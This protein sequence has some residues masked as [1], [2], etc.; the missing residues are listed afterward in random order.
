MP[1]QATNTR[2]WQ[3]A[4][5]CHNKAAFI[6]SMAN[7]LRRG[8]IKQHQYGDVM[9]PFVALKRLDQVLAPH[10]DAVHAG[11]TK[12]TVERPLKGQG[13][14]KRPLHSARGDKDRKPDHALRDTEK[15]PLKEDV[16]AYFARE[17]LPHIPNALLDRSKDKTGYEINFTRYFFQYQPLR[18]LEEIKTDILELEEET[19]GLLK[20]ILE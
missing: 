3:A 16:D 19:G 17:V 10:K 1:E 14:G 20:R 18:P 6:W 7:D 4:T 13:K 11:Y 15:I 5:A 9:L 12:V 8:V 2:E